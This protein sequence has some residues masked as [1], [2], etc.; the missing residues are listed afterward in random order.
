MTEIEDRVN[1]RRPP[2]S[3]PACVRRASPTRPSSLVQRAMAKTA[4]DV[5]HGAYGRR[6]G[7]RFGVDDAP[8]IVTRALQ[9]AELA[10]TEVRIDRPFGGL[11]SPIPREDAFSVSLAL[12]DLPNNSYWE[13]GREFGR[14][15]VHAGESL[16]H[17]L[18][19][20]PM[21][22]V[23]KPMHSLFL[24]L[25]RTALDALA[26]DANVPRIED[27]RYEPG[28]GFPDETIR[29]LGLSLLPAV[30][31][32]D[33]TSRLFTDHLMLGLGAHVAQTYGGMQTHPKPIQGGLAPWQEKRAK[34]MLAADLTG[35]AP[36]HEVALACGLSVSHFSRAFRRSTG[37]AP[38][39]WLLHVRIEAAK[40]MLRQHE[41]PLSSVAL[42]SGFA[43]QSHF[44]RVFTRRV[45]LS[46]G[47]WRKY[48]SD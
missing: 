34:D 13:E 29:N 6:L 33:Q 9:P 39:A 4:E 47:V 22:L 25:P 38:H 19:R 2:P 7:A 11:S 28:V 44:T 17:D 41:A 30:R 35:A 46:P 32:P 12:R 10:V 20:N 24:Y 43:D 37:S 42:A 26:D 31:A 21:V 8:C 1:V 48:L 15:T 27:L 18:R 5:Q 23:D 45:G 36:L 3:L 40:T 14:R 16:I